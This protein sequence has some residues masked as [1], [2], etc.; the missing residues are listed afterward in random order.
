MRFFTLMF[1]VFFAYVVMIRASNKLSQWPQF[2]ILVVFIPGLVITLFYY[3]EAFNN[4]TAWLWYNV[5]G[6]VLGFLV[7]VIATINMGK[8]KGAKNKI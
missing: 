3:V 5:I 2:L 6:A 7:G 4:S 1:V 8:K